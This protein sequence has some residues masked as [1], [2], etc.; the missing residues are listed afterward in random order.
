M[1]YR[2]FRE[3][4]ESRSP[5]AQVAADERSRQMVREA[6]RVETNN[7]ITR[8]LKEGRE[9]FSEVL[10]KYDWN[11]V[12]KALHNPNKRRKKRKVEEDDDDR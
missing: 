1:G 5:E 4:R 3:L 11:A 2:K 6:D 10:A 9:L 12:C 7:E 8:M